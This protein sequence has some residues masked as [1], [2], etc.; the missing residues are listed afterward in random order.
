MAR[1]L[2]ITCGL[3]RPF[4]A[5]VLE[6]QEFIIFAYSDLM[7]RFLPTAYDEPAYSFLFYTFGGIVIVLKG[8]ESYCLL[9]YQFKMRLLIC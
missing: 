2:L 5:A 7:R 4:T 6:R 9:F 1:T 3:T 8:H